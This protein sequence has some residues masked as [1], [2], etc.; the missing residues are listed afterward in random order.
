MARAPAG[1]GA[2]LPLVLLLLALGVGE[3]ALTRHASGVKV[4]GL[5]FFDA[6]ASPRWEW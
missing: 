1:A 4:D 6:G 2:A 3:A 5:P